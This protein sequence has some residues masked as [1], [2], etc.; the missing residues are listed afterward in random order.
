MGRKAA[1]RVGKRGGRGAQALSINSSPAASVYLLSTCETSAEQSVSLFVEDERH[2]AERGK[3]KATKADAP[4]D[5][6]HEKPRPPS[7]R[8]FSDISPSGSDDFA[9]L[10]RGLQPARKVSRAL[11][12]SIEESETGRGSKDTA[13][14]KRAKGR[15]KT[16][17][18]AAN[19]AAPLKEAPVQ[20]P[21]Q[22]STDEHTQSEDAQA[23]VPIMQFRVSTRACHAL[24]TV[25]HGDVPCS[26]KCGVCV[27][28]MCYA[29]ALTCTCAGSPEE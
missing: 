19:P 12:A 1:E 8:S 11:M 29:G 5:R 3:N 28:R 2:I 16:K 7:A 24:S 9:A 13:P 22:P 17:Q 23:L 25:C 14:K 4:E 6:R 18:S 26:C 21:Q 20:Q 27:G 15:A 10:S